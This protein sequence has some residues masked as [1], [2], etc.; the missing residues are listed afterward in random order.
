MLQPKYIGILSCSGE[1]FPGGTLSR[2]ATRKVLT[3]FLP[4]N[5]TTICVPLFLAGDEQEQDFVKKFP[6]V[7]VDGCAKKC[8]ARSVAHLGKKALVELVLPDC[9]DPKDH[10]LIK[11]GPRHDL[12]WKDHPLTKILAEKIVQVIYEKCPNLKCE[13]SGE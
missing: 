13:E 4:E 12:Q 2:I 10:D 9:M 3:D 7:T 6:C 8:A 5:T 11:N 1:E